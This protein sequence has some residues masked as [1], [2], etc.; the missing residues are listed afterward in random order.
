M[1]PD[2]T[3]NCAMVDDD[4]PVTV[5]TMGQTP[6]TLGTASS[7]FFG[8]C[9]SSSDGAAPDWVMSTWTIGMSMFGNRVIDIVRKLMS[10]RIVRTPNQ[11]IAGM[12]LR[13]DQAETLKRIGVPL[14][15]WLRSFRASDAP[16]RPTLRK[17]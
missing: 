6:L 7:T 8:T 17:P 10:P 11:T 4:P 13:I 5:Q 1:S 14:I 2:P 12:G 3:A 15:R 9:D 16:G